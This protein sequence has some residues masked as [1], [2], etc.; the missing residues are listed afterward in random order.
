MTVSTR[1][2]D[3]TEGRIYGGDSGLIHIKD[4]ERE[5]IGAYLA[6]TLDTIM[7][8]DAND[9]GRIT[10]AEWAQL[11]LC[12]GCYMVA[13]FNAAVTLTQ[14]NGQ[15]LKEL[16]RSMADAFARLVECD[17]NGRVN[18]ESIGVILDA[19]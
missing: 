14:N 9:D 2:G 17:E 16:G 7:R 10:D 15:S 12:P 5:S 1:K 3:P 8:N 19:S 18:I 4:G 13:L 11:T 6:A